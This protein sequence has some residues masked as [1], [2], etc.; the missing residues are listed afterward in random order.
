MHLLFPF[1]IKHDLPSLKCSEEDCLADFLLRRD[2]RMKNPGACSLEFQNVMQ[3]LTEC[4][5]KWDT[6]TQSSKGK[7]IL[8]TVIAFAGADKE[9]GR[10]TLHRHWQIWVKEIDQNIRDCLF[11]KDDKTRLEARDTFIKHIDD[12]LSADYGSDLYISHRCVQKDKN[13][14]LKI[15]IA[16]NLLKEKKEIDFRRARHKELSDEAKRNIMYCAE[17]DKTI[18]TVDIVNNSLKRWR[19]TVLSNE[20]AQHNRP[21]TNIPLTPA[22][23]DM[24]AYTFSY[25]MNGGC[26]LEKDCFG[27]NMHVRETLLKHRFKEHSSCH[28]GSCFKTSC[29]CRFMF[30]FM[31][32]PC[33]YIH[34]DKGDNNKNETLW[35]SLD[36]SV[37]TVYPFLILPKRPMGCQYLNSHNTTI[38]Y[39]LNCNNNIQIGDA[40]QVFYSTLYTSK[41]TQ[42]EDSEKQL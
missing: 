42:E 40:S 20:R 35:Y 26:A 16:D 17:C 34:E 9:Q 2:A 15:D 23:L 19:D 25:H 37:N 1:F 36:G 29:E 33:T 21:D 32:T 13:E 28:C 5:L 39:I 31:S 14:E 27:G 4:L 41:S 18:S 8:G 38:S 24:A 22:R 7:G 6:K 3:I 12:V 10:K 30:P 11:H